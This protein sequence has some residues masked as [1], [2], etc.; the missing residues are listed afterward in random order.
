MVIKTMRDNPRT[1]QEDLVN[2][3]KVGGTT[4][5]KTKGSTLH[6]YVL[7]S[8]RTAKQDLREVLIYHARI[9]CGWMRPN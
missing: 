7:K 5:K 1:T 8:Y 3:L 2:D 9:S 4:F 6:R